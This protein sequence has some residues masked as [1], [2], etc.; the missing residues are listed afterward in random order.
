M[1][2]LVLIPAAANPTTEFI[3]GGGFLATGLPT[4]VSAFP[5]A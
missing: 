2:L 4:T 5:G 1:Q 3:W